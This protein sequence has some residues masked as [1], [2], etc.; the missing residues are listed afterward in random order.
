MVE[1]LCSIHTQSHERFYSVT[2]KTVADIEREQLGRHGRADFI[3]I[4]C[5]CMHIANDRVVYM[6]ECDI[7]ICTT[8]RSKSILSFRA[9]QIRIV[10]VE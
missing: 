4:K 2:W 10:H 8:K 7:Y 3:T 1:F 5:I 9:V 6:V